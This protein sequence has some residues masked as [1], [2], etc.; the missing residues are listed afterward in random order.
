MATIQRTSSAAEHLLRHRRHRLLLFNVEPLIVPPNFS[1]AL[2]LRTL[3]H[4]EFVVG[5]YA[6]G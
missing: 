1:D 4:G 6:Q 3:A 2:F 5:C